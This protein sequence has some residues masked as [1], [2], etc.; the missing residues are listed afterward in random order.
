MADSSDF[1]SDFGPRRVVPTA[2]IGLNPEEIANKSGNYLFSFGSPGSG[3]TVFQWHL[4]RHL[5]EYGD[6]T[7]TPS[8][9]ETASGL[10]WDGR[11]LLNEWKTQWLEGRLPESTGAKESDIRELK[12]DV[13]PMAGQKTPLEFSFLEM[14]GELLRMVDPS[15]AQTPRLADVLH[16]Y[17]PNENIRFVLVLIIQPDD[18]LNDNLFG[19]FMGYLDRVYPG[20]KNRM[21]L[22]I[23]VS[24]PH[25]TLRKLQRYG[26]MQ[27]RTEY[28]Q[29]DAQ[30]LE[31]YVDRF[32]HEA[33]MAYRNWPDPKRVLLTPLYI[34]EIESE[35]GEP[36]LKRPDFADISTIFGWVYNQF[37][38]KHLGPTWFQKLFR[39]NLG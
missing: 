27:G 6:F 33:Y 9:P 20:I 5:I 28:H 34:G 4:L 10:D 15:Q 35:G 19:S 8:V 3:K 31:A 36:I 30:A 13:R 17:L 16:A 11:R 18:E 22:S 2:R 29:L 7:T 24:K 39:S 12:L 38:G 23:V 37:T 21:S 26:D 25:E 32:A 14:S 1:G